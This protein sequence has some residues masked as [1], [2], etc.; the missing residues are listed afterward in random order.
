MSSKR[1]ECEKES[2]IDTKK[3]RYS[4]LFQL[5][6]LQA[7]K[8]QNKTAHKIAKHLTTCT[9]FY[10]QHSTSLLFVSAAPLFCLAPS[11]AA[12]S[13]TSSSAVSSEHEVHIL[14]R[15]RRLNSKTSK[16]LLF[17]KTSKAYDSS[18]LQ[19]DTPASAT[20]DTPT[21]S[22]NNYGT[23]SSSLSR[24]WYLVDRLCFI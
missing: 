2:C 13:S 20:Q 17:S 8:Q 24:V 16:A 4:A 3:M 22:N 11:A 19:S 12:S 7:N 14:H 18:V 23:G 5:H 9:I 15:R 6:T 10:R 21:S 1:D